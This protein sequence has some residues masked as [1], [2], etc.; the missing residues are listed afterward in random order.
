[1]CI[2]FFIC[3]LF[4]GSENS[5]NNMLGRWRK[6]RD[7]QVDINISFFFLNQFSYLQ[8]WLCFQIKNISYVLDISGLLD[9]K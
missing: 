4:L 3:V 2:H 8:T 5:L 1:M 6:K 9:I 7:F